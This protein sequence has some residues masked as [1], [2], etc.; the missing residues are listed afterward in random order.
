MKNNQRNTSPD[1]ETNSMNI[2]EQAAE[3]EMAIQK[4]KAKEASLEEESRLIREALV[5][6]ARN[7]EHIGV[8]A[9]VDP[10][11]SAE[12]SIEDIQRSHEPQKG[13][14]ED[15][16]DFLWSGDCMSA[17]ITVTIGGNTMNLGRMNFTY[18]DLGNGKWGAKMLLDEHDP[19]MAQL[20]GLQGSGRTKSV[21]KLLKKI[22]H[23]LNE[24]VPREFGF[25]QVGADHR[26]K[27]GRN[28]MR[29]LIEGETP[30]QIQD[31]NGPSLEQEINK[32]E[33]LSMSP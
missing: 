26:T 9:E 28:L 20:R 21:D 16:N 10:L 33:E 2:V 1:K 25:D 7:M 32:D 27:D 18:G 11:P 3:E 5:E 24:A 12:I 31:S 23:A 29:R 30:R 8:K 13:F 22:E 15:E 19:T 4:K 6:K 17:L 14:L